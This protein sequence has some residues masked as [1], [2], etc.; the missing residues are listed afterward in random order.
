M[1]GISLGVIYDA[2][3]GSFAFGLFAV[4]SFT[5][6]SFAVRSFAI[7]S[8]ATFVHA[9]LRSPFFHVRSPFIRVRSPSFT[10]LVCHSIVCTGR[11]DITELEDRFR[12]TEPE[13]RM[14]AQHGNPHDAKEPESRTPILGAPPGESF[15]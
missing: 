7:H 9:V 13:A 3:D 4:H 12:F 1:K 2:F 14:K 11:G 5:F 8:F 6:C 10:V 15:S